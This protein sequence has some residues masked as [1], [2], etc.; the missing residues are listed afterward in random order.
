MRGTL[1]PGPSRALPEPRE[2]RALKDVHQAVGRKAIV[3]ERNVIHS[4]VVPGRPLRARDAERFLA[5]NGTEECTAQGG[6]AG[7]SIPF[8]IRRSRLQRA[9][10]ELA[11]ARRWGDSKQ[12]LPKRFGERNPDCPNGTRV[13][14]FSCRMLGHQLAAHQPAGAKADAGGARRS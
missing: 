1:L 11:D 10:N 5:R 12:S 8:V 9:K 7:R 4:Q 14:Q 2:G 13:G 3:V 6:V